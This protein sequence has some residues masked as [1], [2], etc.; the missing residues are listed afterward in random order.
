M[1]RYQDDRIPGNVPRHMKGSEYAK[2]SHCYNT[3][4]WSLKWLT[5]HYFCSGYCV[6]QCTKLGAVN[7]QDFTPSLGLGR[8]GTVAFMTERGRD[9]MRFPDF[10]SPRV[11][12]SLPCQ[13][14]R[15]CIGYL[16]RGRGHCCCP[17]PFLCQGFECHHGSNFP[18]PVWFLTSL[19]HVATVRS[20]VIH[21]DSTLFGAVLEYSVLGESRSSDVEKEDPDRSRHK[22]PHLT[23]FFC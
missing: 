10:L 7:P 22:M 12:P 9:E 20:W 15:E 2:I 13:S 5:Q 17:W 3:K 23:I 8:R 16:C 19:G 21:T 1:P 4:R 14:L 18:Y 6:A 11:A